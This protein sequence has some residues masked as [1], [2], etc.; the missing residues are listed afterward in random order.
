MSS[1]SWKAI[2]DKYNI[3]NHN[4]DKEPFYINAKMIKILRQ[5][6]KKK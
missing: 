3:N 2:F 4:F 1:N 5:L 6:L